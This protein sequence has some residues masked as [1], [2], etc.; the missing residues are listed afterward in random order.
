[1]ATQA[2]VLQRNMVRYS[3]HIPTVS[4]GNR[5]GEQ[6]HNILS[7]NHTVTENYGNNKSIKSCADI[8]FYCSSGRK[9]NITIFAELVEVV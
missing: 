6:Q 2:E 5:S 9:W 8:F 3:P 1:M 4:A 7:L